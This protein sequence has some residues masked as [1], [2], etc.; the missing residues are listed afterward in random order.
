[1]VEVNGHPVETESREVTGQMMIPVH[2]G[3]N[4]VQ[5]AFVRTPDRT[6]GAIISLLALALMLGWVLVERRL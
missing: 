3:E 5:I 2:A 4:R 1:M 6:A